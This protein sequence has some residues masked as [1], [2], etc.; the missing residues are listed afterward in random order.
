MKLLLFL[1]GWLATILFDLQFLQAQSADKNGK[2][3]MRN[4]T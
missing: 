1:T 3:L 2:A 4:E